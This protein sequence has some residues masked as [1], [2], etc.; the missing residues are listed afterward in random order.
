[1]RHGDNSQAINHFMEIIEI[2]EPGEEDE[3]NTIN[4]NITED[5][6]TADVA[7]KILKV[8]EKF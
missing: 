4:L 7:S 5:M 2:F 3:K 6:S 1:M 8:I